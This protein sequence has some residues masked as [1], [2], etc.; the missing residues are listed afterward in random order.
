MQTYLVA[1]AAY[2]IPDIPAAARA[3]VEA[4]G[5]SLGDRTVQLRRCR[6]IIADNLPQDHAQNMTD[7]LQKAGCKAWCLP[8][9]AIPALPRPLTAHT[10][11]PRDPAHLSAQIHFSG[12]PELLQWTH[13]AAVLPARWQLTSRTDEMLA[14]KRQTLSA[15]VLDVAMTGGMRTMLASR[16]A[17]KTGKQIETVQN[18]AMVEIVALQPLRRVHA[19]ASRM[20]HGPLEGRGVQGADNWKLLL[21]ALHDRTRPTTVGRALLE[22]AI[23]GEDSPPML[24]IGDQNDLGRTMRWLMI[25]ATLERMAGKRAGV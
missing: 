21:Q 14:P 10:L 4:C 7:A 13:I 9:A 6:G 3:L 22:A 12:P 19:F 15:T 2:P 5:G 20:D 8:T 23:R 1:S 18:D 25:L 16:T 11:D 17:Q 24:H